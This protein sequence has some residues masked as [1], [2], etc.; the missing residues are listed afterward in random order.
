MLK[1]NS[2]GILAF[3]TTLLLTL[4]S[5][6]IL[7]SVPANAQAPT[8]IQ[9]AKG[10]YCGSY[11]GNF[12]RGR[13]FVLKLGGGQTFTSR[14][15]GSGT[16]YDVYVTGPRGRINGQQVSDTQIDY[17]IPVSGD[18]YIYVESSNPYSNIE[19]CAY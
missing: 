19:F 10:S 15:I 14:N 17:Y 9:F 8:R 1:Q 16:Q 7:Q 2:L 6:L 18:Y 3:S 13:K 12:S 11:S 5:S 4:I